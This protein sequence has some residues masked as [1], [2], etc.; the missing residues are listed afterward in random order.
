MPLAQ[1][2]SITKMGV[3]LADA[4]SAA[5]IAA[6]VIG[7]LPLIAA[8]AGLI[9]YCIQIWESRTVQHWYENRKM[10]R[11][12]RKIAKLKARERVIVAQLEA[13]ETLRQAR[14]DARDKVEI[15]KVEAAK[16]VAHEATEAAAKD[17]PA[18]PEK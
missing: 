3:H 17:T 16:L 12:A 6:T 1:E 8:F 15:A 18:L 13:L 14:V 11:K 7:W 5:A 10:V 4:I 9:W 2:Q